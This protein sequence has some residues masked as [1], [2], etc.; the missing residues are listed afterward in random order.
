MN[1]FTLTLNP[2]F[3]V[4]A[5]LSHFEKHAENLATV[6]DRDAGGKGVNISRA[7]YALGHSGT[8]IVAV[9]KENGEEFCRALAADGIAYHAFPLAGRIRENLTLH[10]EGAPETRISFGGLAA[11]ESLLA[12]VEDYLTSCV[13]AG[14]VITLTGRLPNG[15]ATNTVTAFLWR[16]KQ[17]GASVVVDSRSFDLKEVVN[18]RP[19]LIKPNEEEAC[20]YLG[21]EITSPKEAAEGALCLHRAG[22]ENVIIS[23]GKEG[24]VLASAEGLFHAIPPKICAISTVG[25]GDSSIAGFLAALLEGKSKA[26][27]LRMAVACGTAACLQN[28]T[29]PPRAEDVARILSAVEIKCLA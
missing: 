25:A 26:E 12:A 14:D 5:C 7:L 10:E 13:A 24:A 15:L 23:L 29:R 16:M 18:A 21:K 22:V 19:F 1:I 2:A 4:H 27:A 20:A 17:K 28:G 9:G 3:D 6:T 8:A 11:D